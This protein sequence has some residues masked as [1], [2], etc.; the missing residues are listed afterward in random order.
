MHDVR[1]GHLG[2]QIG[3]QGRPAEVGGGEQD[4]TGD[5]R[6]GRT[7]GAVETDEC[8][9][10]NTV[11]VEGAHSRITWTNYYWPDRSAPESLIGWSVPRAEFQRPESG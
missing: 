1:P 10:D 11:T 3:D 9:V 6:H 4:E 2:G 5:D 8:R 7:D